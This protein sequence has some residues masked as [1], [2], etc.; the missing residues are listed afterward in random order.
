MKYKIDLQINV[1]NSDLP[2]RFVIQ[3]WVST[4]LSHHNID[5]AELCIRVVDK[6]ESQQLNNQYRHK[7]YPT[8]VLSFP[9]ELPE[10]IQQEFQYHYLGDIIICADVVA[11][12]AM[13]QSKVLEAHWAHMVIHGLLHLMGYDHIKVSEAKIMEQLEIML[14]TNMGYPNPYQDIITNN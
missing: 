1:N 5:S 6:T 3:R 11:E 10:Y 4:T 12:E 2:N 7:N 9:C 14:L 13:Q 8:N